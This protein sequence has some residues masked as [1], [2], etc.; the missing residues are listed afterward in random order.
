MIKVKPRA[1]F[2]RFEEG[3]YDSKM[4]VAGISV[5]PLGSIWN[6][7]NPRYDFTDYN[8]DPEQEWVDRE[9]TDVLFN[10][11][12]GG[13]KPEPECF[14]SKVRDTAN[15][16]WVKCSHEFYSA[17][18]VD[19]KRQRPCYFRRKAAIKFQQEVVYNG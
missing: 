9:L 2:Y 1:R 16:S 15:Y 12:L 19:Y 3:S 18:H 8:Y 14:V 11:V 5:V 7:R 4:F 10:S 6:E 17:R 13:S